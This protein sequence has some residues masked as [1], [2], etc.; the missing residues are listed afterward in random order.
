MTSIY[1]VTDMWGK[2]ERSDPRAFSSLD[3]AKTYCQNLAIC[4][5]EHVLRDH[6]DDIP[7]EDPHCDAWQAHVELQDYAAGKFPWEYKGEG[8]WHFEEQFEIR[9]VQ[10]DAEVDKTADEQYGRYFQ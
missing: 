1:I 9:L 6:G 8:V 4:S 3:R 7:E 2:I 5:N 10:I